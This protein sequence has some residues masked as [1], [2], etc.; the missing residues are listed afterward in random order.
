MHFVNPKAFTRPLRKLLKSYLLSVTAGDIMLG[1]VA[2]H[3]CVNDLDRGLSDKERIRAAVDIG[4][5][6]T[7]DD[8]I[9]NIGEDPEGLIPYSALCDLY[10]P[11][12]LWKA[13]MKE[14]EEHTH[15]YLS[16]IHI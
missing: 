2:D 13:L 10:D 3:L 4:F 11:E 16:L 14:I 7:V 1:E 8:A 6:D 12:G 9:E 5:T 15:F